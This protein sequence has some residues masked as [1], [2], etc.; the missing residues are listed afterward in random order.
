[1]IAALSDY[2]YY[3]HQL[4]RKKEDKVLTKITLPTTNLDS[5]LIDKKYCQNDKMNLILLLQTRTKD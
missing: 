5:F 1:M 4:M 2:H 3:Y